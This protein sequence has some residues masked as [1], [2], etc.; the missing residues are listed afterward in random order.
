ML[1]EYLKSLVI[2]EILNIGDRLTRSDGIG[3]TKPLYTEGFFISSFVVSKLTWYGL[4]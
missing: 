1:W 2:Q 3:S 4:L